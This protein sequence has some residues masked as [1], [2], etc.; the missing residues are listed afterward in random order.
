[1]SDAIGLPRLKAFPGGSLYSLGYPKE[2]VEHTNEHVGM[3][4]VKNL[5]LPLRRHLEEGDRGYATDHISR[6]ANRLNGGML[7]KCSK[8]SKEDDGFS[9]S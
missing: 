8:S 2:P 4:Q 9:W 7:R 6:T 5:I 3:T 1:M